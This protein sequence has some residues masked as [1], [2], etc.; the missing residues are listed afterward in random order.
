[1]ISK[2]TARQ[3]AKK[4]LI[5]LDVVP[6]EEFHYGLNVELEHGGK[7]GS[8]TNITNEDPDKTFKIVLAHLLEDPRYYLKKQEQKREEYWSRRVKPSIFNL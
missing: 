4:Y 8:C 2:K 5:D 1:M 3:L 7:L 6:F